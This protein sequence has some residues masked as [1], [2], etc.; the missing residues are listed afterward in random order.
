MH[1]ISVRNGEFKSARIG[2][3]SV[4]YQGDFKFQLPLHTLYHDNACMLNVLLRR[5]NLLFKVQRAL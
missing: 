4:G 3:E 5:P 1:F 2:L